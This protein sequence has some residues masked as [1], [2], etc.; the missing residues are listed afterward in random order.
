M[1]RGPDLGDNVR[2]VR[3]LKKGIPVRTLT[4]C[5][6]GHGGSSG[7]GQHQATVQHDALGFAR[8][9][10]NQPTMA[11]IDIDIDKFGF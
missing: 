1:L 9:V 6:L 5:V 8:A 4:V 10:V 7:A 3:L 11:R 2:H